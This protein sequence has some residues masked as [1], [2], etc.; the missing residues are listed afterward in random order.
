MLTDEQRNQVKDIL[1]L[2]PADERA[3]FLEMLAHELR[4][5]ELAEGEL[6]RIA[7]RTW[8]KFLRHG[9]VVHGPGDAA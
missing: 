2:I 3:A 9:W 1:R 5:R 6:R 7:E 4:G 8:Q